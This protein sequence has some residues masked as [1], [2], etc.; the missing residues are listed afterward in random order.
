VKLN[1]IAIGEVWLCS[2]QSNMEMGLRPCTDGAKEI[3]AANYPGIRLLLVRK[4]LAGLPQK[5]FAGQWEICTPKSIAVGP[6]GGFSAAAYFFGRK[7][8]EELKVPVGLIDSSWGGTLIE[9]WT[10]PE[11]FKEFPH[12]RYISKMLDE[13][14]QTASATRPGVD[15]MSAPVEKINTDSPAAI[16]NAMIHPLI[17]FAIHGT[18]WFQGER[19][20][21]IHYDLANYTLKQ[22]ALIQSWRQLWKEGNLPFYYVQLTPY[23]EATTG[24]R[25]LPYFWEAQSAAQTVVNTGMVITRDITGDV[26]KHS[27]AG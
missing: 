24:Y 7:L 11:G 10:P 13:R 26:K 27:S 9:P 2:G 4:K 1:N 15:A 3:A 23:D 8:H 16:Y 22:R 19:N 25:Y 21:R 18:L 20:L 14:M 17:P 12:F 5:D 6:F